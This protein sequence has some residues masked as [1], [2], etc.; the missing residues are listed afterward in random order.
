VRGASF[1]RAKK[2]FEKKLKKPLTN[3][4][5]SDRIRMLRGRTGAETNLHGNAR[6]D[7]SLDRK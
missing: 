5:K 1:P 3:S 6:P 2:N 4:P 7:D